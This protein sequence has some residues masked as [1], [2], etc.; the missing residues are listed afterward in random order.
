MGPIVAAAPSE[1]EAWALLAR[2]EGA[3]AE[4]LRDLG[5]EI[6]QD[7]AAM[8]ARPGIVYPGAYRRAILD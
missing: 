2:R 5:W 1:A 3:P 7:L 8:P 6:A 4:A